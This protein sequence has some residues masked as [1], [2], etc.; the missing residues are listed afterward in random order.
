[1]NWSPPMSKRSGER[2]SLPKW[3]EEAAEKYARDSWYPDF[4]SE[5]AVKS[6]SEPFLAGI[7]CLL[8]RIESRMNPIAY[9][10]IMEK[11]DD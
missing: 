8:D 7:Q 10:V 2:S 9:G 6:T 5:A 4:P 11:L 1:M 3:A